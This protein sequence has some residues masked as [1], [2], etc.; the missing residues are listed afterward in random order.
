MAIKLPQQLPFKRGETFHASVDVLDLDTNLPANLND[1]TVTSQLWLNSQKIV[2]LEVV[3]MD[4]QNGAFD[5]ISPNGVDTLTWPTG[6]VRQ[7][8]RFAKTEFGREVVKATE[9]F[10]ILIE[11]EVTRP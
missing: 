3:W 9:T 7:D 5:L 6:Q 1:I 11:Q 4:R 10:Y 2:D 8:I